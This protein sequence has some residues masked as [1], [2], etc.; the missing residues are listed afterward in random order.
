MKKD[1]QRF[2]VSCPVCGSQLFKASESSDMEITCR[3][4]GNGYEVWIQ[5]GMLCVE[6]MGTCEDRK[7]VFTARAKAYANMIGY[8]LESKEK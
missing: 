7:A 5:E 4:C 2:T 8:K 1:S 6:Q 3:K